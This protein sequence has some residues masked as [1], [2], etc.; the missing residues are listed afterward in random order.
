M[1]IISGSD[2][3]KMRRECAKGKTVNYTKADINTALQAVEDTFE[4]MRATLSA[5]IDAATSPLALTNAQ[6]TTLVKFWL[7]NKFGRE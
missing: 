5:A 1:A 3:A 2:L 4:G 6:K 7:S